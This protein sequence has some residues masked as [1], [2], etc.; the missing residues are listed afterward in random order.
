MRGKSPENGPRRGR[1]PK[2]SV[3]PPGSLF[4]EDD[5][6]LF[7]EGSHFH[8]QNHLGSHPVERGGES[9]CHFA[10]FAPNAKKVTVIGDFNRWDRESHPLARRGS[11]GVWE[12]FVPGVG[13]GDNYKYHL[14]SEYAGY[15]V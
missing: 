7:H 12:G 4:S 2:S 10:V 13:E 11:S 1:R 15:I 14:V 3:A 8:L 5:L 6:H 9:G